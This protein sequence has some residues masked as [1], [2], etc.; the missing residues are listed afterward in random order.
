VKGEESYYLTADPLRHPL[1]FYH[2]HTS[3][4]F[5]NKLLLNKSIK[6]RVNPKFE[7]LFAIGVDEMSWD[8]INK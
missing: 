8:N 2:A 1:I 3:T 7:S 6:E 5:L 4:F